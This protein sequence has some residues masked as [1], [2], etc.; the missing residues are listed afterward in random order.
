M[1][2]EILVVLVLILV[3]GIFSGAEI[4][5]VAMRRSRVREL[6]ESGSHFGLALER[7][8]EMGPKSIAPWTP[9]RVRTVCILSRRTSARRG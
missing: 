7:L 3:G 5:V 4:A 9:E 8:R 1:W 2:L 6:A